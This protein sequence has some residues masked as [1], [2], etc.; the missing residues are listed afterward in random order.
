MSSSTVY[1]IGTALSRAQGH[2]ATV[3]V[4]VAGSWIEGRVAD[5]DGEG[6]VL[7]EADDGHAVVRIRDISAVR[8]ASNGPPVEQPG[9]GEP[10]VW[11]AGPGRSADPHGAGLRVLHVSGG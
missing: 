8:V 9:D 3:R 7:T 5:L 6:L 10:T 11:T 4:L 2:G 1:T